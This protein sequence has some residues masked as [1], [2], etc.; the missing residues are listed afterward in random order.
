M[1]SSHKI[2][3]IQVEGEFLTGTAIESVEP[4]IFPPGSN[5]PRRETVQFLIEG[6]FQIKLHSF[7]RVF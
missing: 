1:S 7:N 3:A 2:K 5:Y 6:L 4:L